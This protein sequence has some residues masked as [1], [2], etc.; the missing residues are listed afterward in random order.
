MDAVAEYAQYVLAPQVVDGLI[1]GVMLVLVAL[2]LTLIFGLLDVINLAHGELYMLGGYAAFALID[3]GMPFWGAVLLAPA[4]VAVIGLAIERF[5]IQALAGRRDRTILTILLT[6][7][8]SLV[9]RDVVQWA[10]GPE[11]KTI[12][13]P[14]TGVSEIFGLYLPNYRLLIFGIGST[15]ILGTWAL[16][17]RTSIG[18][19]LRAAAYD[20]AM[21]ASLGIPVRRVFAGTFALGCALAAVSGALLA[22]VYAVFPTMGHDFLLLAF[23]TVIVGGM[24]SIPGAV[25]AGLL[26]AQVQSLSSLWIPPVW[27]ETMVFVVMFLVLAI[28]PSGLFGRLGAA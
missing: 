13:K 12:E 1:I 3:A 28:R 2:G 6:F 21:T 7:G 18:A 5:G 26:L 24:G 16:I 9:L 15:L 19:V 27:A 20:H 23:A 4:I 8:L 22:P 10:W 11:T 25:A 14:I 17:Y